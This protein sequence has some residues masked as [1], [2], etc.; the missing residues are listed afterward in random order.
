MCLSF[1]FSF[2]FFSTVHIYIMWTNIYYKKR[3]DLVK[4]SKTLR[5]EIFLSTEQLQLSSHIKPERHLAR[6]SGKK[7]NIGH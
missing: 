5:S 7:E 6:K 2:F 3:K 1:L 4:S